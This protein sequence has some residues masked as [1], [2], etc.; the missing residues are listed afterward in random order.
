M[1][2]RLF[3][4]EA[5]VTQ[6]MRYA[7]NADLESFSCVTRLDSEVTSCHLDCTKLYPPLIM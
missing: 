1:M 4:M 3:F 6:T 5:I 2:T 7:A